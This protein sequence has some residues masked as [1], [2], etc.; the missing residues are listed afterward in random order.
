MKWFGSALLQLD[1]VS[2]D[3]TPQA[4]KQAIRLKTHI[5]DSLSLQPLTSIDEL[6]QR[7]NQYAMLEDDVVPAMNRTMASMSFDSRGGNGGKGEG[8]RSRQITN[9]EQER[10]EGVSIHTSR[11]RLSEASSSNINNNRIRYTIS[12]VHLL[13]IIQ[14]LLDFEWP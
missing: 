10:N 7:G 12:P 2:P 5:F 13:P 4:V 3:T 8:N 11:N 6:F 9:V 14:S 1:S